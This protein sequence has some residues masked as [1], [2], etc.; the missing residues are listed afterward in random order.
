MLE[1]FGDLKP[2]NFRF[3]LV[4]SFLLEDHR[5]YTRPSNITQVQGSFRSRS[6]FTVSYKILQQ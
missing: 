4:C 2:L 5:F 3:L 1:N 6:N